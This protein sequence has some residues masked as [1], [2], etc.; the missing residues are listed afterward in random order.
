MNCE[1]RCFI[2]GC[3]DEESPQFDA[4]WLNGTYI[5]D[6]VALIKC[7]RYE[8]D[9]TYHE[10]QCSANQV[11]NKTSANVQCDRWVY[12]QS[13]FVNTASTDFNFVCDD[14]WKQT[15]ISSLTMAGVMVGSLT[16]GSMVDMYFSPFY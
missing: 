16:I 8:T 11:T 12:D 7:H 5:G 4:A 14:A 1:L 6:H 2:P 10:G 9:V 13:T 3:D 15:F